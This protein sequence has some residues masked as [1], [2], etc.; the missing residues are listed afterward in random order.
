M[1]AEGFTSIATNYTKMLQ[2]YIDATR[3]ASAL[4]REL[5]DLSHRMQHIEDAKLLGDAVIDGKNAEVRA[6]QLRSALRDDSEYT[7]LEEEVRKKQA[8]LDEANVKREEA[9]RLMRL[10]YAS[11]QYVAGIAHYSSIIPDMEGANR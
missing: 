8:L 6:A 2:A 5:A 7:T 11:L 9:E 4:K 1:E 10:A 3:T